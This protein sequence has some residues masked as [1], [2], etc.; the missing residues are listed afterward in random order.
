MAQRSDAHD[1]PIARIRD[2]LTTA[3]RRGTALARR[4]HPSLSL[5]DQSLINH[6]ESHPGVRAVDIATHFQLHK[7]TVS[8]QL[9]LLGELGLVR[10]TPSSGGPRG[11][12]LELTDEGRRIHAES[13]AD[14]LHALTER[15]ANWDASDVD[16][17]AALLHRYNA[18]A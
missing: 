7:S 3:T 16:L 8:R 2:E 6:I 17:F 10:F 18:G 5:V 12:G 4:A 15:L 11:Q 1:D 13:S 9:K 14:L